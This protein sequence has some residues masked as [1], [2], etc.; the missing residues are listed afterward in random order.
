MEPSVLEC[1]QQNMAMPT[2]VANPSFAQRIGWQREGA[3]HELV[4][5]S[6]SESAV[7]I[8]VGHVLDY[9]L[10]CGPAGNY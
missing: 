10:H 7:C 4:M 1:L 2:Y 3:G 5:K 8:I 6:S 9:R